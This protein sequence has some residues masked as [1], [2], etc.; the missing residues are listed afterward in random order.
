MRNSKIVK[1]PVQ[2]RTRNTDRGGKPR[3][4]LL[5]GVKDKYGPSFTMKPG[6]RLP[7]DLNPIIIIQ[8]PVGRRTGPNVRAPIILGPKKKVYPGRRR[9][10]YK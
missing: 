6:Q 2:F 4:T 9:T 1:R 10:D 8:T 3:E 5:K 7:K